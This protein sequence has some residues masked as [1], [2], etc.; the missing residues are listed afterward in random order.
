MRSS[1]ALKKHKAA[2]HD[3]DV[4]WWFCDYEDCV[5]RAKRNGDITKHK[6][7][8]HKATKHKAT[9]HKA[10]KHNIRVQWKPCPHC[11]CK[12]KSNKNLTSHKVNVHN[13]GVQWKQC[14]HCEH[15]A[16][17]T[18]DMNVHIKRKRTSR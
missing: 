13:A 14:P 9:K 7:T 3:I 6:A 5:H 17:L 10:T 8:K 18:G 16:K 2:V 11:D 15:K 4:L 12:A 1:R